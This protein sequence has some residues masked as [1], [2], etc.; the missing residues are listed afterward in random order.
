MDDEALM[1]ILNGR[2]YLN[3]Q[4]QPVR[5]RQLVLVIRHFGYALR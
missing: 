1:G 4:L 5:D 2:A 3:E